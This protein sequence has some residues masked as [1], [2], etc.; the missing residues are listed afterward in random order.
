M[1]PS[2]LSSPSS[3]KDSSESPESPQG[4]ADDP[5]SPRLRD[6]YSVAREIGILHSIEKNFRNVSVERILEYNETKTAAEVLELLQTSLRVRDVLHD[7]ERKM[8]VAN[9]VTRL[10]AGHWEVSGKDKKGNPILW[11][12]LGLANSAFGSRRSLRRGTQ[13]WYSAI[14]ATIYV[15]ELFTRIGLGRQDVV[16]DVVMCFDLRGQGWLDANMAFEREVIDLITKLFPE[17]SSEKFYI[18]GVSPA[19]SKF[20]NY[21]CKYASRAPR[22]EFMSAEP[23]QARRFVQ[24]E[25]DIPSWFLNFSPNSVERIDA[26][27]IWGLDRFLD[28]D[29]SNRVS[30]ADIFYPAVED[31][32]SDLQPS[33][34]VA[35]TTSS[36]GPTGSRREHEL[37]QSCETGAF[38]HLKSRNEPETNGQG[39]LETIEEDSDDDSFAF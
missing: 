27:Q 1:S 31:S 11:L 3:S 8:S 19:L 39:T 20:F 2:V 33:E 6:V 10:C 38:G 26:N 24:N 23:E 22:Y 4:Q 29:D 7:M 9:F 25:S 32:E 5:L 35:L 28:D 17:T 13:E 37:L 30:H 34:D 14:R 15:Y 16:P 36:Q 18:F 21:I 12:R